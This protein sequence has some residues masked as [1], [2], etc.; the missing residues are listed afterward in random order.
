MLARRP[1][2]VALLAVALAGCNDSGGT[3]GTSATPGKVVEL[4][5]VDTLR[6]AFAEG[7]GKPRVLLLLSPT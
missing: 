4:T 3:T 2:A 6:A 1:G 7:E 5:S